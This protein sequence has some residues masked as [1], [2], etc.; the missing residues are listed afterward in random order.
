[1]ESHSIWILLLL[2]SLIAL[3]GNG[4][5]WMNR[6]MELFQISDFI[7]KRGIEEFLERKNSK[8]LK[9][10]SQP[11]SS[12]FIFIHSFPLWDFLIKKRE[13]RLHPRV[14]RKFHLFNSIMLRFRLEFFVLCSVSTRIFCLMEFWLFF[15]A[16]ARIFVCSRISAWIYVRTKRF[17]KTKLLFDIESVSVEFLCDGKGLRSSNWGE[18]REQNLVAKMILRI[19]RLSCS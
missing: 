16:N 1:M 15:M 6:I 3:I 2:N 18:R 7:A 11:T 14:T 8:W 5:E 13:C 10:F 19:S 4:M 12:T 17:S 9:K